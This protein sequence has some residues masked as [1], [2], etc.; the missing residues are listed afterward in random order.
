MKKI[1]LTLAFIWVI[2][3][4]SY[5][6]EKNSKASI[7]KSIPLSAEQWSF[8][9]GKV[10]FLNFKGRKAMKIAPA[11]GPV[12]I[13]DLIFKDGTIEYDVIPSKTEF[14]SAIYFHRKNEKEQE[15]VYLRVPKMAN[16]FANEGIQYC[17]ILDGVNMWDIYP[18]YQAPAAA[19][20]E[21]WNH[22]KLV[23]SGVQMQVFVN[24]SL[25]LT[26]P[27]LEGREN[28]GSIAFDGDAYISNIEIK[29]NEIENLPQAEGVDLTR[30]EA[31]YIRSWSITQPTTLE[32]G[33]EPTTFRDL[34]K[35]EAFT[36]KIA[37]ERYGLVN[38]T[39]RFGSAEKRRIIWLKTIITAQE[40]TLANLQLGFSDEIWL[41]LNDQITYTDK[42][43]FRQNM[44]RYPDGR[45]S[46][47]NGNTRLKLKKGENQLLIGVSNDF[48]GW[49]LMARL[50]NM[51][52]ITAIEPYEVKKRA[53]EHIE[54]YLGTY[55][56]EISPAFKL[57]FVQK[58]SMLILEASSQENV[59]LDYLGNDLFKMGL[60][61]ELQF[62]P[63][64]KQV[65]R[66]ENGFEMKFI[67]E[68]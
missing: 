43:I 62:T 36:E 63:D 32:E 44:K 24:N 2:L 16:P 12:V 55:A 42:N 23:I 30:H 15:I 45:I 52:N 8:Q 4:Q 65:V 3:L 19:K 27:K 9:H 49:G 20:T 37:T 5:T 28:T 57:T 34:P 25:R 29:P 35:D 58:D 41:Y 6:Q 54:R 26:V 51:E 10:D 61:I 50:E 11:S 31:N 48:Y 64:L 18:Q 66:K 56:A 7:S 47:Q 39:R 59:A 1:F 22:I 13:K 14:A 46:V 40:P 21:E 68:Q 67:K 17:P 53:I 60:G 38:L 33:R